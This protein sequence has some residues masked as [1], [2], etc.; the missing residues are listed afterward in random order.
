MYAFI[1]TS[2]Y[3]SKKIIGTVKYNCPFYRPLQ[4]FS[5]YA[6]FSYFCPVVCTKA[7]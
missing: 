1:F 4:E 2:G 5:F 3:D 6:L 7:L